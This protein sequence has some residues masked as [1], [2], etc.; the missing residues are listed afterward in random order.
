M[1]DDMSNVVPFA[2][3]E[4]G[5]EDW[6]AQL[7]NKPQGGIDT[8]AVRNFNL[9]A[10]HHRDLVGRIRFDTFG[11]VTTIK[12]SP[13]ELDGRERPITDVDAILMR[14][15][16][17]GQHLQP[18]A[19]EARDALTVAAHRNQYHGV[20]DYL[21]AL[22]WDGVPRIDT[23][24]IDIM[25]ASD[26]P[27]VRAVGGKMLIGAVA[28]VRDPG[29]Q[30]DTMLILAGGEG[31]G[32]SSSVAALFHRRWT[33]EAGPRVFGDEKRL[34]MLLRGAW[35]VE[36]AELSA[37]TGEKAQNV[38]GIITTRVDSQVQLYARVATDQPR[39]NVFFGTV[40]PGET[41]YLA[42]I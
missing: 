29:C 8:K 7:Q 24:L 2:P 13:W 14:E 12:A 16:L 20:L 32:K 25:G 28:R 22:V 39:Q 37:M 23:W 33:R 26:M 1:D 15:W 31:V 34:P 5:E 4:R 10:M 18:T 17:Q 41:G 42:G 38:N 30:M 36:L 3:V 21:D 6:R 40:N 27:Y 19:S 35:C 11:G 9:Y